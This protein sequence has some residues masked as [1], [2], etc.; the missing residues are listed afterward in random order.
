[1]YVFVCVCVCLCVYVCDCGTFCDEAL[2]SIPSHSSHE[3]VIV[4]LWNKY[5]LRYIPAFIAPY[6]PRK[7]MSGVLFS[8]QAKALKFF[9]NVRKQ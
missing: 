3:F 5:L 2:N 4:Y 9:K 6:Y 1:M 7:L 8:G